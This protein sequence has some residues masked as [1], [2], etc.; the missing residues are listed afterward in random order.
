MFVVAKE[1][2]APGSESSAGSA[3]MESK[4]ES[5]DRKLSIE[6]PKS[7]KSGASLDQKRAR[8][9]AIPAVPTTVKRKVP[10]RR[11]NSDYRSRE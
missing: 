8:K 6:R 9:R 5:G 10:R 7:G 2:M 4:M 1:V 3:S 11:P